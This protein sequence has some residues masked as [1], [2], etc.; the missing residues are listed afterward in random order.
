ML[1]TI[2]FTT[3]EINLKINLCEADD[4]IIKIQ[5]SNFTTLDNQVETNKL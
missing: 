3:A 2:Y 1:F 4:F 5:E